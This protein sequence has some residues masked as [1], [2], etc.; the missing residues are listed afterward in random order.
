MIQENFQV[1]LNDSRKLDVTGTPSSPGRQSSDSPRPSA[2]GAASESGCPAHDVV[3]AVP[4]E[5]FAALV[6]ARL[7]QGSAAPR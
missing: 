1:F 7:D 6:H 5:Q 4:E 3:E 2:A